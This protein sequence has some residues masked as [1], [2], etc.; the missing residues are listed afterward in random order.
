MTQIVSIVRCNDYDYNMAK[1]AIIELIE[2][3]GGLEKI[4]KKGQKVLIKANLLSKKRPDEAV[5]THPLLIRV[6]AEEL[7][8]LGANV[9]IGDSPGGPF[10]EKML[11]GIYQTT[12]M[13]EVA[14]ETG[15][16]LN[17]DYSYETHLFNDGLYLRK[18]NVIKIIK[19]VDVVINF[20]KLKTHSMTTYTGAVKNLFGVIPGMMKV[21]Y[22]MKMPE[23]KDFGNMLI[24]IER[25]VKPQLSIIDAVEGME[26]PGPSAGDKRKV[27]LLMASQDAHAVDLMACHI[28]GIKSNKVITLTNAIK[29]GLISENINDIKI[30]GENI[31]KINIT[32]F[33]LPETRSLLFASKG[34]PDFVLKL[35]QPKP[36]FEFT[37]CIGCGICAGHCPPKII[38]MKEN[39]PYPHYSKCIRCF[40]CQELCPKKAVSIKNP[41][42]AKILFNR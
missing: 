7:I 35:V 2:N 8:E 29:R 39:K 34:L 30:V 26:G 25:F 18:I 22:H 20:A 6:L 12:G 16:K 9:I 3:L 17:D 38:N 23:L 10:N 24:D 19:D 40:C 15:A 41:I 5:T 13:A 28:I 36:I 11:R 27:G 1:K 37:K 14:R 21:E 33:K 4:I 42:L 32:P 31:N